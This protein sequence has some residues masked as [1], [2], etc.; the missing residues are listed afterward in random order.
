MC[1]K[2]A[3][4]Y[5]VCVCVLCVHAH[6]QPSV[7]VGYTALY[8]TNGDRHGCIHHWSTLHLV[9]KWKDLLPR[10]QHL[11][12]EGMN[13][14]NYRCGAISEQKHKSHVYV[15]THTHTHTRTHTCAP[16][17]S[18]RPVTCVCVMSTTMCVMCSK[19]T[20][21]S[22]ASRLSTNREKTLRSA[23]NASSSCN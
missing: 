12:G 7:L 3:S 1:V 6:K 11:G 14:I 2:T 15:Q 16:L 18:I 5:S 13:L 19:L 17:T 4:M 20:W 10:Y 9:H 21:N 22:C 8:S 23:N